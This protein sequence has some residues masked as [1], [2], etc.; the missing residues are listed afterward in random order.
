MISTLVSLEWRP[1]LPHTFKSLCQSCNWYWDTD[2][3]Y[4]PVWQIPYF[5]DG[6]G[7]KGWKGWKI[8]CF[9]PILVAK[10]LENYHYL[11]DFWLEFIFLFCGNPDLAINKGSK[12]TRPDFPKKFRFIQKSQKCA[13]FSGFSRLSRKRY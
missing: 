6:Q 5:W 7:C 8:I 13:I 4:F 12:V 10:C 3:G 11:H 2:N 9:L 1:P